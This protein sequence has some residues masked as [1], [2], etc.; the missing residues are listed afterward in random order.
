MQ[1]KR[2]AHFRGAA[3]EGEYRFRFGAYVTRAVFELRFWVERF[4]FC[5]ELFVGS[6]V[7]RSPFLTPV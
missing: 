3:K 4:G 7:E 5:T 2:G 6:A 1:H